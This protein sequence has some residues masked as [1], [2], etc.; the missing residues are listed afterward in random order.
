MTEAQAGAAAAAPTSPIEQQVAFGLVIGCCV[1]SIAWGAVNAILVS[2]Q[3][4]LS[5]CLTCYTVGQES[6]HD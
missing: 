1:F 4:L 6:G 5:G 2:Y 3:A